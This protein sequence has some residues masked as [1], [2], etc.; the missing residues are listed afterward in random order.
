M[1]IIGLGVILVVV[2]LGLVALI[3]WRILASIHD[4]RE[5]ARFVMDRHEEKWVENVSPLYKP[6]TTVV[7][8]PLFGTKF[9]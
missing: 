6:A 2:V 4:K 8:N 1:K 9:D 7:S 3:V 5:Y